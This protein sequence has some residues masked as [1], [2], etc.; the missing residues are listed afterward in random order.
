VD[1]LLHVSEMS[2]SRVKDVGSVVQPGQAIKVAVLKIDR[3][4]RKVSLGLK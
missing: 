2:W 3:E 4:H 1:G